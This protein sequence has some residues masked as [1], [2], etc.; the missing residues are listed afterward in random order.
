MASRSS[1]RVLFRRVTD[2]VTCMGEMLLLCRCLPSRARL[3]ARTD[4]AVCHAIAGAPSSGRRLLNLILVTE[5]L[6]SINDGRTDLHEL[7][8]LMSGARRC[9]PRGN[10]HGLHTVPG[11]CHAR[12]TPNARTSV[13]EGRPTVTRVDPIVL[14]GCAHRPLTASGYRGRWKCAACDF[15]LGCDASGPYEL[16]SVAREHRG[17]AHGAECL[18][19]VLLSCG[20]AEEDAF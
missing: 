8:L 7:V 20:C 19:H 1:P 14:L 15:E 10:R 13:L 9:P 17:A 4:F 11:T 5:L 18:V 6:P 2:F 16:Y 12:E 3:I